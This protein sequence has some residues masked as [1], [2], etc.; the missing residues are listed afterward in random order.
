[1]VALRLSGLVRNR[2]RE[3]RDAGAAPRGA[4]ARRPGVEAL[5]R[6]RLLSL[7]APPPIELDLGGPD[8][9]PLA[10]WHEFA[11]SRGNS[12]DL[13]TTPLRS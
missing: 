2:E 11:R 1:M 10:A 13:V 5:E 4:R 6:R 8:G 9:L 7:A 12:W 3:D